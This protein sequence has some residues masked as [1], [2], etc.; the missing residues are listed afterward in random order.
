MEIPLYNLGDCIPW[1]WEELYFSGKIDKL[2]GHVLNKYIIH[3]NLERKKL[4]A[5]KLLLVKIHLRENIL[6]DQAHRHAN[7]PDTGTVSSNENGSSFDDDSSDHL[8]DL[9]VPTFESSSSSS[10]SNLSSDEETIEPLWKTAHHVKDA[11]SS[12]AEA[13][14]FG[15]SIGAASMARSAKS[16]A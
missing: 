11:L 13:Q 10:A 12:S 2:P 1:D 7:H 14:H 6:P 9:V 3:F 4:I 5:D 15:P 16:S 8:E